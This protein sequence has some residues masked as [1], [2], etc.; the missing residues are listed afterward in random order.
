MNASVSAIL[1]QSH[2]IAAQPSAKAECPFC[3]H[4]TFSIKR[5]DL[6]EKCC[7]P[8]CGR[9]ITPSQRDG[10]SPHSVT[11][12]LEALPQFSSR[13]SH[14][15]GCPLS[16]CLQLPGHQAADPSPHSLRTDGVLFLSHARAPSFTMQEPDI[17]CSWFDRV[18]VTQINF[19]A[20]Q[21][22]PDERRLLFTLWFLSLFFES[23]IRTKPILAFIDS[24]EPGKSIAN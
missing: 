15:E 24:K 13:A 2:G 23:F 20:D 12:V 4:K 3:H 16:E 11:S 18:I 8:A 7:H 6:L 22:T 21:L 9:F 14:P 1:A 17:A 5:N 19:A 10:Q